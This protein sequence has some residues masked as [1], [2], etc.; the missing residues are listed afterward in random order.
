M[1][2]APPR[3]SVSTVAQQRG[4]TSWLIRPVPA[5]GAVTD[6]SHTPSC[7]SARYGRARV[8]ASRVGAQKGQFPG[9][10]R[11]VRRGLAPT[12]TIYVT[13]ASATLPVSFLT[14]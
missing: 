14:M 8:Q 13:T 7:E 9:F 3:P 6:P 12:G 4:E 5:R 11:S 1:I 10:G 2:A